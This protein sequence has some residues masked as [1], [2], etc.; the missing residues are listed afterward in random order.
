MRRILLGLLI[1]WGYSFAQA[2]NVEN[3]IIASQY[4]QFQVQGTGENSYVFSPTA[5]QVTAGNKNFS[6]LRQGV[7]VRI[8]DPGNH[9]LDETVN[10]GLVNIS[11]CSVQLAARN[12]HVPPFYLTSGTAGL[13]EA[14]NANAASGPAN[15]IIIETGFYALGGTTSVITSVTGGTANLGIVDVTTTPYTWYQWNGA[16][17]ATVS[18]GN[19]SPGGANGAIQTNS[20][21]NFAGTVIN[22]L[23]KG[24]DTGALSAAVPGTDYQAPTFFSCSG[25]IT[26]P[27]TGNT[28]NF[29]YSGLAGSGNVASQLQYA[30]GG[31]QVTGT[32]I[33]S[34]GNMFAVP[35]GL[36]AA[37]M[38]SAVDV[39]SS[40]SVL[41]INGPEFPFTNPSNFR[42][43]D[44]RPG[45]RPWS[46]TNSGAAC[47]TVLD[48]GSVTAGSNI[49]NLDAGSFAPTDAGDS[50]TNLGAKWISMVGKVAGV[51]TRFDAYITGVYNSSQATLSANSPFA[52][53][54]YSVTV[55]NDDT[56]QLSQAVSYA[57]NGNARLTFPSRGLCWTRTAPLALTGAHFEGQ[58]GGG[59][60]GGAG[61]DTLTGA[62]SDIERLPIFVDSRID[63]TKAWSWDNNGTSTAQTPMYRPVGVMTPSSNNPLGPGWIRGS[64][65]YG[66][67]AYNGVASTTSGS[68][69]MCVLT[70]GAPPVGA[71]VVF[72]YLASV[73]HTTVASMAG[74]CET[75]TPITLSTTVPATVSQAEYFFGEPRGSAASGTAVQEIATAIP[76]TGRIFPMTVNLKNP[77]NPE[78]GAESDFAPFGLIKID[79]EE[80]QYYGTSSYP[81]VT[82]Q[83][84]KLTSCA[85]NGTSAAAHAVGAAIV[86]LNPFN[87]SL[88]WPVST[89]NGAGNQTPAGAEYFPAFNIGNAAIAQPIANGSTFTGTG[90]FQDARVIGNT[91]SAWPFTLPNGT[92]ENPYNF[93]STNSTAGFYMVPLPFNSAFKENSISGPQ[94]GIW[95]GL[96]SQ[97]NHNTIGGFTADTDI[98]DSN[99]ISAGYDVG[100]IGGGTLAFTNNQLF[101]QNGP[102]NSGWYPFTLA[103]GSGGAV[104]VYMTADG[105]DDTFGLQRGQYSYP[106]EVFDAQI[107]GNSY[108]EAE[109]PTGGSSLVTTQPIDVL[110]FSSTTWPGL[111]DMAGGAV[112]LGGTANHISGGP[113]TNGDST[114]L[115]IEGSNETIDFASSSLSNTGINN[116]WGG[117]PVLVWGPNNSVTST[118]SVGG[119]GRMSYGNNLATAAGQTNEFAIT[120]NVTAPYVNSQSGFFGADTLNPVGAAGAAIGW[121]F[122]GTA[123]NMMQSYSGCISG[124]G[125]NTVQCTL[126]LNGRTQQ[127]PII[128]PGQVL[129]AGKYIWTMS[130]R[131]ASGSAQSFGA[132]MSSSCGYIDSSHTNIPISTTWRNVPIGVV[133]LSGLAGCAAAVTIN[134]TSTAAANI[135]IGYIS[136]VPMPQQVPVQQNTPA[137]TACSVPGSIVATDANYI[138]VCTGTGTI[139]RATLSAY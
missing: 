59:I 102:P 86:P 123:E 50:G 17:Y 43:Q 40:D 77:N 114:P 23:V 125:V 113:F 78:P 1:L 21:G 35:N 54:D 117:S 79:S 107:S 15:T 64:E 60:V 112:Y 136:L 89:I 29:N 100:L 121:T 132:Y 88:P 118:S 128:G 56:S 62:S 12:R 135:E 34:P 98:F 67:G 99:H 126:F 115:I 111:A 32:T 130:V 57:Q 137:D 69:V 105:P 47:N 46:V 55:G 90:G 84:I 110:D 22:G 104:C 119:D 58:P 37:L 52:A 36:S 5:C 127:A 44:N 134:G 14:I 8:V 20:R 120:G 45:V 41:H 53:S 73:L 10:A 116:N 38:Q 72:P 30:V 95:E 39:Q 74:T 42:V 51:P 63:A 27:P 65:P 82:G 101:S 103:A 24:N 16:N 85:Q 129:A 4:G 31:Y 87:P 71:D 25:G 7:P 19:G 97:D 76:A 83:W 92:G 48:F 80:C 122:D 68:A 106:S 2:Q 108:C 26:C 94:F 3:Q 33:G 13:Q 139:K 75:G 124:T 109:N 11:V 96:P 133:D 18:G 138:Y 66:V 91:I 70:P 131:E 49:L 6:A 93:Q 61:I 28:Y 81:M 9:A